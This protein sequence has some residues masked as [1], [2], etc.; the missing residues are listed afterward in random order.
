M[1]LQTQSFL[2]GNRH[3]AP[4]LRKVR[5]RIRCIFNNAGQNVAPYNSNNGFP[6]TLQSE[7]PDPLFFFFLVLV[8]SVLSAF[9]R[10]W[11]FCY[12]SEFVPSFPRSPRSLRRSLVSGDSFSPLSYT[13][14]KGF[15]SLPR[16]C[17][18]V[19]NTMSS[20]TRGVSHAD[21][22]SLDVECRLCLLFQ[23]RFSGC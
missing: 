13:H 11:G 1:S 3:Y 21:L 2:P 10:V 17:A 23:L 6:A 7:T 8:F 18:R 22:W 20:N 19:L 9:S 5:Q 15:C 4:R 14:Q 16:S 12:S